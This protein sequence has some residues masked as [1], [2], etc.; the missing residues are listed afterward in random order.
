MLRDQAIQI[1]P[2]RAGK[3]EQHLLESEDAVGAAPMA[4]LALVRRRDVIGA[5]SERDVAT[6]GTERG[7]LVLVPRVSGVYPIIRVRFLP[8][9]GFNALTRLAEL[10]PDFGSDRERPLVRIGIVDHLSGRQAD[11]ALFLGAVRP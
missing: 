10:F 4:V 2:C 6:R 11:P 5:A 1:Q 9:P 7:R 3:A 8:K